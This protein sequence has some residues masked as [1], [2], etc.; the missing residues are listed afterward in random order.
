MLALLTKISAAEAT[1]STMDFMGCF[2]DSSS[3]E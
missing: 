1:Q 2:I 3:Q